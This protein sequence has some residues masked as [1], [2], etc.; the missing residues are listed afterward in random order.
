MVNTPLFSI[1]LCSLYL[2][3]ILKQNIPMKQTWLNKT[4]ISL[5]SF[6]MSAICAI[7]IVAM[8][9]VHHQPVLS[10]GLDIQGGTQCTVSLNIQQA[11]RLFQAEGATDW[12]LYQTNLLQQAREVL[13]KRLDQWGTAEPLLHI[14]G[15]RL[16][17]ELPGAITTETS[18]LH[19]DV[20]LTFHW[21]NHHSQ[22]TLPFQGSSLP[23]DRQFVLS[24]KDIQ[25]ARVDTGDHGAPMVAIRLKSTSVAPFEKATRLAIGQWMA[26]VYDDVVDGRHQPHVVNVAR[27]KEALSDQF[28]IT[29]LT[30]DEAQRLAGFIRSGALPVPLTLEAIEH[31]TP[32]IG[33]ISLRKTC[34]ALGFGMM[35]M[36]LWMMVAYR[37][38]GFLASV[39]LLINGC[40]LI[41]L[42][43][44]IG[45][46]LTLP[47]M[48]GIALTL[49]MAI[50]AN[51]LV[52]ERLK[53]LRNMPWQRSMRYLA[54]FQHAMPAIIDANVTTGLAV[55][56]LFLIG[57]GSVKGF[58]LTLLLGIATSLWTFMGIRWFSI[59]TL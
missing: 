6:G 8:P 34:Q 19:T 58:A 21:V 37:W 39:F 41:A 16:I 44:L 43:S 32:W 52:G 46:T 20:L 9:I 30:W 55:L 53:E 5:I 15:Q 56:P 1:S 4:T 7:F 10:Y 40:F 29:G 27:I 13:E 45:S 47:T 24:G 12:T 33:A 18:L 35:G 38:L 42:L 22:W 54:A 57:S 3:S 23:L 14:V 59:N 26:I 51:V 50:D 49:G 48:I 2:K 17:I 36:M 11:K 25:T 28:Q 31:I